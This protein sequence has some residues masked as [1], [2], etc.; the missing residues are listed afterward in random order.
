MAAHAGHAAVVQQLIID[1]ADLH[2]TDADGDS[3]IEYALVHGH[4]A[5]IAALKDAAHSSSKPTE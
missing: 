5:I 1:G 2:V 3:A 4:T